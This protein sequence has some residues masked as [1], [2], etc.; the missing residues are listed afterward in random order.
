MAMTY[1]I[2]IYWKNGDNISAWDEK[3]IDL[4]EKFGLPGD[5]YVTSFSENYLEIN[6]YKHE[7][8]VVAA[9]MF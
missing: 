3:C 8:A 5:R 9:L 7:D 6:F 1:P 2:K 4:L